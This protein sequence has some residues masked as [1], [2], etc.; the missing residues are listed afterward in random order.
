MAATLTGSATY[1]ERIAVPPGAVLEVQLADISRA[2]VAADVLSSKRY[3]LQGV[4]ADF[5]LDYDEALI[6]TNMTYA[7][8]ASIRLDGKLLFTTD[9]VYPVL[10]RGA[11]ERADLVLVQVSSEQPAASSA[12]LDETTWELVT[13]RGEVPAIDKK[14]QIKF[15]QAGFFGTKGPCNSFRG[16]AEISGND[17]HFPDK[18][19][20]TLMACPPNVDELEQD[21]LKVLG[22][23]TSYAREDTKL[24]LNNSAGVALMEFKLKP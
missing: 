22:E 4:P 10:T 20:G 13:M 19:A 1:R 12:A 17:I 3:A 8:S 16:Q 21:Y 7:V 14:P 6:E 15:G 5:S 18:M 11:P 2:D 9:T 23:V 24:T